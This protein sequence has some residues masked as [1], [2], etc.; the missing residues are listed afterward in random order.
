MVRSGETTRAEFE[1][2]CY[3]TGIKV[4]VR[5]E[6][7]DLDPDGYTVQVGPYVL[8]TLAAN[9]SVTGSWTS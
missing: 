6:G 1:V 5:T 8:H 3:P 7:L 2:F 9:G 4:V